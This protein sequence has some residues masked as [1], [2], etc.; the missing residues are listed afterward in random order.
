M[1]DIEEIIGRELRT[2]ALVLAGFGFQ[3]GIWSVTWI[4][5]HG[6]WNWSRTRPPGFT[7]TQTR[8]YLELNP[9]G[10]HGFRMFHFLLFGPRGMFFLLNPQCTRPYFNNR[11]CPFVC[12]F[13]QS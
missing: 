1:S 13:K 2:F 5:I 10:P 9:M 4:G 11:F 7:W 6:T 8:P 12:F 3:R